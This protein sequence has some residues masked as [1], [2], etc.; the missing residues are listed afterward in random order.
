MSMEILA[1]ISR[2]LASRAAARSP[3]LGER[4]LGVSIRSVA[5][6]GF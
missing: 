2:S 3:N 1:I 5:L 6:A 4:L